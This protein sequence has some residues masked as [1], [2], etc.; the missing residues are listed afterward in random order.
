MKHITV[1][2]VLNKKKVHDS[3]FLDEYTL[4]PYSACSFNCLFCYT[5]GSKYGNNMEDKVSVKTN[6][7]EVLE[8]QL[9]L[10]AKKKQY[11]FIV[12]ASATDPYLHFEKDTLLTRGML[13]LIHKYRF[14]VHM[15]TRSDMIQRDFDLLHRINRDSCSPS[16]LEGRLQDKVLVTFSFSTIE[17]KVADIFEPGATKIANRIDTMKASLKEGFRTGISLMP[18]LPFISDT[19]E[20]LHNTF[21]LFRETGVQYVLPSTLTLFG[22]ERGDSKWLMYRAIEKHYPQLLEKYKTWFD[23]SDYMPAFYH[24]A[25]M[26]KFEEL[27]KKYGVKGRI[28]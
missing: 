9:A 14:P 21:A 23:H 26:K 10:R 8:K 22:N 6:A 15:L 5:Q 2:S 12:L 7:L 13:E 28:V 18:L 11:G 24:Q 16:Y 20:Q 3:W 25:F 1:K 19:K 17:Q 27:C 4:N